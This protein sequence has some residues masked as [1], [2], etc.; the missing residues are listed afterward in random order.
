[1][2]GFNS[3]SRSAVGIS[4]PN[5]AFGEVSTTSVTP[6]GQGDFT[7]GFNPILFISSTNGTGATATVVS[8]SLTI[9]SGQALTG[10]SA[11]S[12][13]KGVKYRP[14]QGSLTRMTALFGPPNSD[15]FQ[16]AGAGNEESGYYFGYQGTNFGIIRELGGIREIRTLTVSAGVA[17]STNVTVTLDGVPITY[18]IAGGST[19]NQT[20][21]EISRQ[22]YTNVGAGWLAEAHDGIITFI[23]RTPGPRTGTFSATGSGLSATFARTFA[24]VDQ[25]REFVSQSNWNIDTLDGNGKSQFDLNK[26][27]GNVYQIGFQYLG[28]GNATFAVENSRTG[29]FEPCHNFINAN[30]RTSPVLRDPQVSAKW[31]VRNVNSSIATYMTGVSAGSFVE[32]AIERN[33]GLVFAATGS[34]GAVTTEV[35]L[36]TIRCDKVFNGQANYGELQLNTIAVGCVIAGSATRSAIVRMYKNTQLSGPVNFQ[37]I[38][39]TKS[40]CSVD[41]SATGFTLNNGFLMLSFPITN[42][43]TVILDVAG[44]N[45]FAKSGESLT[46]TVSATNSAAIDTTLT[47]YEDQ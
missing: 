14:G 13:V 9:T 30:N 21:F 42:G 6:V 23:C 16:L 45:F 3:I 18:S 40:L 27:L 31:E 37:K 8:G 38:D 32:G 47:W 44:K 15:T 36:M 26:Q 39:A 33:I 35:P 19:V 4:G 24:G 7:H 41:R 22:D 28:Y 17:T 34:N 43:N 12:L 2:S 20:S 25:A 10:S 1:M 5:S 29:R 11:V 46:V